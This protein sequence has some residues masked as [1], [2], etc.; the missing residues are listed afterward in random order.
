M[1][2]RNGFMNRLLQNHKSVFILLIVLLV[3]CALS[4]VG[5]CVFRTHAQHN[6]G[7]VILDNAQEPNQ[8]GDPM[9]FEYTGHTY[10]YF[11]DD[12]PFYPTG[13]KQPLTRLLLKGFL[14]SI[15][16]RYDIYGFDDDPER[17]FLFLECVQNGTY[18]LFYR[19]DLSL[20][21]LNPDELVKITFMETQTENLLYQSEDPAVIRTW[22]EKYKAGELT[23]IQP[24][25]PFSKERIVDENGDLICNVT[26]SVVFKDLPLKCKLGD[27]KEEEVPA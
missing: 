21:E 14:Y 25:P 7:A 11:P 2:E 19:S 16:Y 23:S 10:A 27:I 26:V 24:I 6:F 12:R 8:N 9:L 22:Y 20:P 5:F 18:E 17:C 15:W 4:V 1:S 13:Q 3:F